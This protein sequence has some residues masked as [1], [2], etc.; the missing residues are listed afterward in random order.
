MSK[1]LVKE[2]PKQINKDLLIK[3]VLLQKYIRKEWSK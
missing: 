2:N 3:S 1:G